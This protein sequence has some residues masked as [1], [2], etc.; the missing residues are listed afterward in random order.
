LDIKPHSVK[1]AGIRVFFNTANS[2]LAF[3]P[4]SR[5]PVALTNAVLTA[6]ASGTDGLVIENTSV[7]IPLAVLP[8]ELQCI[9][10]K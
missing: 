10:T 1:I 3:M 9:D 4:L 8:S 6:R 5:S 2:G 7:S